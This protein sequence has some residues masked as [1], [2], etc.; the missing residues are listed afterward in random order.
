MVNLLWL[1][2][3]LTGLVVAVWN[4]RADIVPEIIFT[5]SEKA[6]S[7]SLGLV[8][9][10]T[11][12]LGIMKII[13]KSGLINYIKFALKP[14]AH[15]VFP[16]VPKNHP[17]M[18]AILMNMSANLL[19]MGS[20]ATPFGLKAMQELKKINGNSSTASDAMCTF[21]AL[22]TSSLTIIPTTIIGLRAVAGSLNPA[23][24]VGTTILATLCSTTVA[25]LLDR[26]L[27]KYYSDKKRRLIQ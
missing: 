12:W 1:I 15:A 8:S 25:L 18:N 23:E 7:I 2:F 14:F 16:G 4:G 26:F 22:N 5:S 9:I 17:A 3:M 21:L 24:V 6:V 20:A 13:E 27:R 11:F 19:G 10:M